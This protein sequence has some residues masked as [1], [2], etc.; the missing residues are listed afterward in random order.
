MLDVHLEVILHVLA[1]AGEVVHHVDAER[2]E[3]GR[4]A[5]ARELEE[6]RRVE[7]SAT[8]DD[9]STDRALHLSAPSGRVI[10]ADRAR[11]LEND[12]RRERARP[13]IE[14]GPAHHGVQVRARRAQAPAASDVAVEA[15]EALLAVSVDVIGELVA[16]LLS[17]PEERPGPFGAR[18]RREIGL[19]DLGR[20]GARPAQA[21]V[22]RD[23]QDVADELRGLLL[24]RGVLDHAHPFDRPA[25]E[26]DGVHQ[27]QRAHAQVSAG[28][29]A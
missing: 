26:G 8:A 16:G 13:D 25:V 7:G 29:T 20:K 19:P 22:E 9:L 5:D 28:I 12:L 3:L 23:R 18:E 2:G 1:D 17:S 27:D 10:D 4:V 14:V 6:L 11:A 15:G 21:E 24:R